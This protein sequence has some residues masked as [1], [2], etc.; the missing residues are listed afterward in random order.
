[1]IFDRKVDLLADDRGRNLQSI[2]EFAAF[3]RCELRERLKENRPPFAVSLMGG[4]SDN[5]SRKENAVAL[6]RKQREFIH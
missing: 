2:N 5:R 1:M 3:S 4:R 6:M